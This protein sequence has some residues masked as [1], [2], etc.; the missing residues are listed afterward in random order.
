[1]NYSRKL[2]T[3]VL[4]LAFGANVFSQDAESTVKE[5]EL[6]FE[7]NEAVYSGTLSM[8]AKKDAY[9]AVILLSGTGPQ[10]R[11]WSF[12]RGTYKMAKMIAEHLNKNGIAVYRFDDR[13]TGKS[14]GTP[15]SETSFSDLAEDIVVAVE[16]LRKRDDIKQVG[17]LGHSLG[18]ILSVIVAS[19]YN[20]VDFIISLAGSFRKGEDILREQARTMKL[21]RT[22]ESQTDEEVIAN[23]DRFADNL[24]KY[25]QTGE[26]LDSVKSILDDLIKF[27]ISNLPESILEENLK[28]YKDTDEFHR[29]SVEGALKYYTSPHKKSYITYDASDDFPQVVC[30]ACVIFGAADKH[31]TVESNKPPL[32]RALSGAKTKDFTLKIVDAA[33][34]GF[35]TSEL[36]QKGEMLPEALNFIS[37]WILARAK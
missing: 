9:P 36:V 21:W 24:V 35:S 18:G 27:Q 15:E 20:N 4:L 13:G 22:A 14:T 2:L 25:F 11:D 31:V 8:P 26:G 19:E 10:D 7:S 34:H 29:K 37:N 1:M 6:T 30:P 16:T 3:F 32:I 23:G 5:E 28:H 12:N 17:L 33:D